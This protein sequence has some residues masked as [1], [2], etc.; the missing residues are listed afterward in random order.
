MENKLISV[1]VP[2]YNVERYLE[3]C[4]E[5]ICN[6]TY[7]CMEII[8]V[9]DG[10]TDRSGDIC[11]EYARKDERI[12]VIHKANGGLSD[13][14]NAGIEIA[15]GS[16]LMFVDSDDTITPDTVEQ[17]YYAA[18]EY[19]C[20]I[21]VCNI[22]RVYEDGTTEPFYNPVNSLTVWQDQKR[23]ETL[24]QPSA[25]NKLFCAELF[26]DVRFPKGKFYEDTFVYH[27]LAYRANKIVLTGRDGYYYL[28]RRESI[29]GQPQY[30]DR[31]FDFV[32]AVYTRMTYLLEHKVSYYG[33]EACLSL[34]AAVS[35]CEKYISKTAQN[36]DKYE[37]MHSWYQSAY[38]HLMKSPQSGV[39]QKLRLV[40]LRYVPSIH[41]KLFLERKELMA[42]QKR[43]SQ[44]EN[45]RALAIFLVVLGHSIILYSSSWDIYETTV[46]VPFLD[47]LKRLIDLVQ[48]PLFF[49]LSG[50]LFAFTHQKRRGFVYLLKSKALR[51]LVPYFGI[52]LCFLF[53]IRM[54]IGF[55]SYQ[56]ASFADIIQKFLTS[57]DV[58]HLW[59]LPALFVMFLLSDIILTVV[60]KIP[61]VKK[62][63]EVFFCII[64]FGLYLEGYRIGFDYPPLLNTYNY[65][66]WFSIGYFLSVWQDALQKVYAKP[67]VKLAL[68]LLGVSLYAYCF[69]TASVRVLIV[70]LTKA[71]FI[72]NIYGAMPKGSCK[73]IE[74][75]DRNSFGLYLFHSPL[76]YITFANIPNAHPAIVVFINLVIFGAISFGLTAL[77]RKTKLKILVGE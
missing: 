18:T 11:D 9:D 14:R 42:Q 46:S 68:L 65:L 27:I 56:G 1:V 57:T 35:N 22:V 60:E 32:E 69:L 58:G 74:K 33:E 67:V 44:I 72:L 36:A 31:Y 21:A 15:T 5:S 77:I 41:S 17:L 20:Q 52:G 25:C 3:K 19:D 43:L 64:A 62:F 30:T 53:P 38:K 55:S 39:K 45:I 51:L 71:L 2:V 29:L 73:I 66:I 23:F 10:A 63:P 49:S 12:R 59:F 26:Q 8:L 61:G 37:Q 50:Y 75:I 7:Y 13:A 24:K 16:W 47:S 48:M 6:Q 54:A 76:I 4:I 40:L 28:S 70:L 34:Y